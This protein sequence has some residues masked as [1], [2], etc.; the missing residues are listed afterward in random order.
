[1]STL[2]PTSTPT[3]VAA[4]AEH[5]QTLQEQAFALY[6]SGLRSPAIAKQLGAPE[7]TVRAWIHTLLDEQ[8]AN[9]SNNLQAIASLAEERQLQIAAAAWESY[10][11]LATFEQL[12][13]NELQYGTHAE[14]AAHPPH[15]TAAGARYLALAQ[16]ATHEVARLQGAYA[17]PL[18][19][20]AGVDIAIT[21]AYP[22]PPSS[23]RL[24][25]SLT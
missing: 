24:T 13:L 18:P 17:C 5:P 16:R 1:M 22:V 12:Q 20:P 2:I 11:R 14:F 8:A 6:C 21:M 23:S 10:H 9:R 15:I 25:T 4:T 7:R 3:S 19:K